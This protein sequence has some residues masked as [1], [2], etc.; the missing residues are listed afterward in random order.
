[1]GPNCLLL[2]SAELASCLYPEPDQSI[3]SAPSHFMKIQFNIILPSKRRSSKCALPLG[4]PHKNYTCTSSVFLRATCPAYLILLDYIAR[5][6]LGE[7]YRSISSSFCS[8]LHSPVTSSLLG[9]NIFLSTLFSNT[10]SL[11]S[12]LS[13][14]N[15]VSHPYQTTGKT[16]FLYTGCHRRNGP[17][18]GRVFLMLNYTDITQNTYIQS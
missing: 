4:Y 18:F 7:Q 16:T 9:P 2:H 3:L 14:R 5:T 11:C 8:F 1:M 17:N 15:Q 6:I 13:M 12:S 10:L